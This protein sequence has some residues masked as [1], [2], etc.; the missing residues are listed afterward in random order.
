LVVCLFACLLSWLL[1]CLLVGWLVGW[2]VFGVWLSSCQLVVC[3][4]RWVFGC[5]V[6]LFFVA[7]FSFLVCWLWW[8][9]GC[10]MFEV[11]F[12]CVV[13]SLFSCVSCDGCVSGVKQ[14]VF[15]AVSQSTRD[16]KK[17]LTH[18]TLTCP[19]SFTHTHT[20][21]H[22]NKQKKG[23]RHP[24][25]PLTTS[26]LPAAIGHAKRRSLDSS[27]SDRMYVLVWLIAVSSWVMCTYAFVCSWVGCMC[28]CLRLCVCI[29]VA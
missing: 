26:S 12:V 10:L 3:L 25:Y 8:V 29:R 7:W 18:N 27:A 21:T 1:G 28:G 4:P 24:R 14:M 6:V 16:I 17:R 11:F 13:R 23:L 20:Y 15:D 2:L 19:H 22:T 5:L 9:A